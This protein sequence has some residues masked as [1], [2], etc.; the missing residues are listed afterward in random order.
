MNKVDDVQRYATPLLCKLDAPKLTSMIQSI[1]PSLRSTERKLQ[2][3]PE[4][5]NV[6][7]GEINKLIK[8]GYVTKLQT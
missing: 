8:A 4:K 5:T 6:Y 7:S 3:D 2:S 1:M